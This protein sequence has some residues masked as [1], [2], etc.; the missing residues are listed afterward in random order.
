MLAPVRVGLVGAGQWARTMHAPLHTS[1][2]E[3]SLTGIWS[4]SADRASVL[5]SAFG[6][7]AFLSYDELLDASDA[8][9]FAVPPAVQSTLAIE[10]VAVGKAVLL[11]K[12]LAASLD[13]AIRLVDAIDAAGVVSMVILTKRYHQRTRE[14]L[15]QAR[16]LPGDVLAV[17]G[18]YVHGGFLDTG[19]VERSERGGW[20]ASLG[21]LFDLGPHLLDLADAAAGRILSIS[22]AG[23][24]SEVVMMSTEHEGGAVGQ[25][26][27]SGRVGTT[28]VLTNLDVYAR[29]GHLAYSTRGLELGEAMAT[30]R[31]EFAAAVRTGIS[32]SVDSH[33]A[34][35]VQ[36][37]IDAAARSLTEGRAVEI[38]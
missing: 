2:A 26:L 4:P 1:G 18:R 25:F 12:P 33:R 15:A 34:L 10:A 17:T 32:V 29:A 30:L 22:A 8:V 9:D 36:R 11:E 23:R 27:V 6:V 19:F 7:R 35:A 3:T 31:S 37:V 14:F 13:A 24:P 20:R 28:D 38:D 5:A 16:N 21:A